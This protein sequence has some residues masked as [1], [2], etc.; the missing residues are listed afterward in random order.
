M[1]VLA[2][3]NILDNP[4]YFASAIDM[5]NENTDILISTQASFYSMP[6][7]HHKKQTDTLKKL[8]KAN[9]AC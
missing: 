8:K 2:S 5:L 7:K 1:L 3:I 4:E 6:I 9:A